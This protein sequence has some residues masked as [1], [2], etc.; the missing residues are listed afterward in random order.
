MW[1]MCVQNLCKDFKQIRL[2]VFTL[3]SLVWLNVFRR[4]VSIVSVSEH[5]VSPIRLRLDRWDKS[6]NPRREQGFLL[7]LVSSH[8]LLFL[9]CPKQVWPSFSNSCESF[10]AFL[11]QLAGFGLEF[12]LLWT[13]CALAFC[14]FLMCVPVYHR[15]HRIKLIVWKLSVSSIQMLRFRSS[16]S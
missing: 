3:A 11:F 14:D 1:H 5:S 8:I 9:I 2:S 16:I 6:F 4:W 10:V 7:F 12:E 13:V 15:Q